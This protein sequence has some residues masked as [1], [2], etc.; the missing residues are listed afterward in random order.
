MRLERNA[1]ILASAMMLVTI[2]EGSPSHNGFN[3]PLSS[4]RHGRNFSESWGTP[5]SRKSYKTDLSALASITP[6]IATSS[7]AAP[8]PPNDTE[9]WGFFMDED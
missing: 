2:S 6:S 7:F 8:S 3:S 4:S 5:E 9:E 1:D